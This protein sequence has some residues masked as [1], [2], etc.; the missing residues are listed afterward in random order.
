MHEY[1]VLTAQTAIENFALPRRDSRRQRRCRGSLSP[2]FH[3]SV[4]ASERTCSGR[5]ADEEAQIAQT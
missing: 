3:L 4:T 2:I 5:R 1:Y